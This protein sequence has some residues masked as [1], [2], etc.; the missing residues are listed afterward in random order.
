MLKFVFDIG[1]R[2]VLTMI[3]YAKDKFGRAFNAING[4]TRGGF[5]L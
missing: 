1:Q 4:K 2:L 3:F 5:F